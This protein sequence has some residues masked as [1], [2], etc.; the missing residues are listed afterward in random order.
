MY[1]LLLFIIIIRTPPKHNN[2]VI[3]IL[4]LDLSPCYSQLLVS[5]S[6][7]MKLPQS[8][9]RRNITLVPWF[10]DLVPSIV[11]L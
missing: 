9:V 6:L 2:P 11:A 10:G 3:H 7:H 4:N 5:Y 8:F 1:T